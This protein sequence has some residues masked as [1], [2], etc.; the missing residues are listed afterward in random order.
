METTTYSG[1]H[2]IK[3]LFSEEKPIE[4]VID[5]REKRS[6]I[7]EILSCSEDVAVEVKSL[8]TGDYLVD[9]HLL[10]ERK[11]VRDMAISIIDGRLFRQAV[12][13][14]SCSEFSVIIIEGD[15]ETDRPGNMTRESLLGAFVSMT[16]I[17]GI[18]VIWTRD[19]EETAKTLLY[20]AKQ[21]RSSINDALPRHGRRPKGKAKLQN[22]ILQGLPGIGP[23]KAKQLIE[24]FGNVQSVI[25][26]E[27]EELMKIPGIGE[28]TAR[29]IRWA[30]Q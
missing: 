8:K 1:A 30:V 10:I 28:E 14:S 27:K 16:I 3:T 15:W 22:F 13:L 5:E 24:K 12:R 11:T 2:L 17:L 21:M 7:I 23:K 20:A 6:G 26:A 19:A 18:A 9:G 4:V 25:N 29:M